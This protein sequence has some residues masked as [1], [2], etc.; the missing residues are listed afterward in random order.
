MTYVHCVCGLVTR[1]GLKVELMPSKSEII[2][3][4]SD[5]KTSFGEVKSLT[6]KIKAI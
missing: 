5:F 1:H 6:A 3:F 2:Y 4:F